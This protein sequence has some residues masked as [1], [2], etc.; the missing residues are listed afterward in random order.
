MYSPVCVPA[1]GP[2]R[3][4][5]EVV[6]GRFYGPLSALSSML[7]CFV[8]PPA[9]LIPCFAPCDAHAVVVASPAHGG[10]GAGHH[11]MFLQVPPGVR[12]GDVLQT[13]TREGL[14]LHVRV[15]PGA[16]AGSHIRVQY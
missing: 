2:P 14:V 10:R 13:T 16:A 3:H 9:A 4:R 15:P 12:P 8:F 1:P 5:V 6:E 11:R 7:L